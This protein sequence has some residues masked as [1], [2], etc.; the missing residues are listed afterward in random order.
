[1]ST[2]PASPTIVGD[3]FRISYERQGDDLILQ[4]GP[5]HPSTHGVLR[6]ELVMDGELVKQITPHIG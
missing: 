1:M 6:L 5:Q 2:A 3:E 4:M